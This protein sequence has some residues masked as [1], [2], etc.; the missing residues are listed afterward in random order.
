MSGEFPDFS[1]FELE[2]RV[3]PAVVSVMTTRQDVLA[4]PCVKQFVEHLRS[5]RSFSENTI[6][7]YIQDISQFAQFLWSEGEVNPPFKWKRV[8]TPGARGFLVKFHR[9]GNASATTRRK[10]ASLRSFFNFLNL[11]INW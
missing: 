2:V 10:L 7:G 3:N 9:N 6:Q 8:T 4:D 5:V 11:F 1:D